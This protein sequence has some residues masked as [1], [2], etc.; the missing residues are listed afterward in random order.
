MR[1]RVRGLVAAGL[2]GVLIAALGAPAGVGAVPPSTVD[3]RVMAFNI[4]YGGDE[5]SLGGD[6]GHW[7]Q[8]GAGCAETMAQ[9]A[10]AIRVA[11]ADIVGMQEGTGNGCRI[12]AMLGWWCNGRLQVLSR[13]PLLDPPGGD[14][15]YVHVEV[16]P[17]RVMA[18]SNVHL[19]SDP[20]GPYFPRDGWTLDEVLA[21]EE[22][23][24]MPAIEPQLDALP[25]LAAAGVPVVLTGDFNSPSHLDWTDAVSA[26]RPVD[27]PYPIDWPVGR[28]LA[29]AGFTDSYRAANPDPVADPGFTWTPGYPRER[30]GVEVQ[31]RIDWVLH[32][33]PV[34]TL[35]SEL[36]G[37]SAYPGTDIA[38]DP[39]PSDHRAVVSTLRMTPVTPPSYAAAIERRVVAGDPQ[40]VRWIDGTE[41]SSTIAVVPSGAGPAAA[42]AT[43]ATG[44]IASGSVTLPTA[45]W[46][47]GA[48]DAVL[49]SAGSVVGDRTSFRVYA[50]GTRPTVSVG[51]SVYREGEPIEVSWAAAPGWKWDWL[52]VTKKGAGNVGQSADCTGGYCGAAGYLV[53]RYTGT[54]VEGTATF[55]AASAQVGKAAWPLPPGWYRIAMYFDDGYALLAVSAAFRVVPAE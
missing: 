24:R 23:L 9:V 11:D 37:E 51:K 10:E 30:K 27:V 41:S 16:A 38:L 36:V 44:G 29:D 50:P 42:I 15:T 1:H 12:A 13:F 8:D 48:Y 28:A 21:L 19:P 3:V 35:E 14:G 39:W 6:H 17:G 5:V 25:P 34:D 54:A 40:T 46:P 53:W 7:C 49:V 20:Y 33:G 18:L 4:L 31:D 26:V 47:P 2:V 32:A 43:A 55:D 52:A 45:T 22:E